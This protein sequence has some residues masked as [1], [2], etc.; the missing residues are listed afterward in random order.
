MP[1][2]VPTSLGPGENYRLAFVTSTVRDATS[3]DI[4]VYNTFVQGVADAVPELAALGLNWTAIAS[5]PF[6]DA[7][8]N[9]GTNP[10]V[11]AGFPIFLLNDT[12]LVDSYG[13]LWDGTTDIAFGITEQGTQASG[14]T[15]V[16]TGS[17][18]SGVASSFPLGGNSTAG[19]FTASGS[20]AWVS[21][22]VFSRTNSYHLYAVSEALVVPAP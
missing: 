2:T 9:T 13:D 17:S 18:P 11:S 5:T 4:T 19:D 10:M 1:V 12:K 7:Q 20:A 8:D 6:D 22:S 16:W 15:R 14:V 3:T 21:S